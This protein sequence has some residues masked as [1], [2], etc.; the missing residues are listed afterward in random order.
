VETTELT[1]AQLDELR[2]RLQKLRD[3]L[4]AQVPPSDG[5][6]GIHTASVRLKK[7][8]A[9]LHKFPGGDYGMCEECEEPIGF[10]R[11]EAHPETPVCAECQKARTQDR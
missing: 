7:V 10:E 5:T 11:L 3:E 9:A 2:A 4:Q 6:E 1:S 8:L